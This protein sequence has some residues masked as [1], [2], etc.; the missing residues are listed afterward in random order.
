M[1]GFG[2]AGVGAAT[3]AAGIQSTIGNV[4]AGS[5]FST[6]TSFAMKG[7]FVNSVL[8]GAAWFATAK[9]A[10]EATKE[11]TEGKAKD[12]S[13]EDNKD[14]QKEENKK[15]KENKDD[16]SNEAEYQEDGS[17]QKNVENSKDEPY[18]GSRTNYWLGKF[19]KK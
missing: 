19:W 3:I 15:S 10:E 8:G 6:C 7:Y 9:A 12:T 18:Q 13:G 2:T 5:L 14:I 1:I 4:A 17:N 16:L 11:N